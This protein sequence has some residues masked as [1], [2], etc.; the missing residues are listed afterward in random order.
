MPSPHTQINLADLE[1]V[2]PANGFGDRWEAHVAREALDA[3]QTGVTHS[4]IRLCLP[5][6][7]RHA[8]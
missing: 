1:N 7:H 4:P 2:A 5:V 3:E 8:R 6:R